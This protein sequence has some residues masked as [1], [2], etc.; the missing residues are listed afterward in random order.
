MKRLSIRIAILLSAI[1]LFYNPTLAQDVHVAYSGNRVNAFTGVL[2]SAFSGLGRA[3]IFAVPPNV[4][5]NFYIANTTTG[6]VSL[7]YQ[8]FSTGAAGVADFTN[9][10]S[11]WTP[12]M[13][14]NPT[15]G[16]D[17]T[18]VPAA[19]SFSGVST[20]GVATP[21]ANATQIAIVLSGSNSGTHALN[22]DVTFTV[23]GSVP[24]GAVQGVIP[25]GA[26][27]NAVNPIVICGV[28]STN[29]C[30]VPGATNQGWK[31]DIGQNGS[32]SN[33]ANETNGPFGAGTIQMIAAQYK[34]TLTSFFEMQ[35]STNAFH[36]VAATASG[37]TAVWTPQTGRK[38]VIHCVGLDITSDVKAASAGDLQIQL[39][40]ATTVIPGFDWSFFVPSTAGTTAQMFTEPMV[41]FR[42]GYLSSTASNVL[43]VNLSFAL[44]AGLVKIRV[45]GTEQ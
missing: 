25:N 38:F 33:T 42:N 15:T 37:N 14:F 36:S 5:V 4:S 24:I 43:N 20:I 44:T 8:V 17:S 16:F 10:Q 2:S 35:K 39:E 26:T 34:N 22:L 19:A 41:C 3:Y 29:T 30:V 45:Y 28:S 27:L 7:N 21:L 6:S 12:V 13:T 18:G 23:N 11:L 40:D 9:N 32:D 1:L 31:L